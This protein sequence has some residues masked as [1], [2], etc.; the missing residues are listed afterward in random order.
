MKTFRRFKADTFDEA[1]QLMVREMGQ[2]AVVINTKEVTEGGVLGILGRKR[3]ELTASAG[4]AAIVTVPQRR[5][6]VP[7][8]RYQSQ[9]S[10]VGSDDTMRDT[11]A[12]FRRV[13]NEAQARMA[14]QQALSDTA[15]AVPVDA[16][17]RELHKMRKLLQVLVAEQPGDSFP[18]EFAPH[19]RS[20]LRQGTCRELAADLVNSVINGGD[21]NVLRNPVI[22]RERLK[23]EVQRRIT[24]TGGLGVKRGRRKVVALTGATGVGKT[25]NLAKLAAMYAVR[26]R[27]RVGLLTTDT[28]RVAAPEQLNVYAKIIGLPMKIANGAEQLA[29]ALKN[30]ADYDLVLIDTAGGS[31]FNTLQI[32]ELKET[33]SG[34]KIDETIL[35]LSANTQLEDSRS[36]VKNFSVLNP[37]SL[38]F[39]KLDETRRFGA[40][41]TVAAES[42]VPLSYFSIGQN[43]PDDI[44]LAGAGKVARLV[45][46]GGGITVGSGT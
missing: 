21:S 13:V 27:L 25:T 32:Q 20:L 7:E 19:Y 5:R 11:V 28:Y 40:L 37:T 24:V 16:M 43:V 23:L 46:S 31:Q 33:L 34:G 22:F 30:Y 39:S 15:V 44:E 35:V 6:S 42:H 4:P 1:Y 38:L 14:R 36:A 45:A 8:M 17:Q 10:I 9:K 12:F 18:S 3:V 2:D 41:L 26:E 29:A